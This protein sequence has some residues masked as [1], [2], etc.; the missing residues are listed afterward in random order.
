MS[1]VGDTLQL[2]RYDNCWKCQERH[3]DGDTVSRG[4]NMVCHEDDG[5]TKKTKEPTL[6]RFSFALSPEDKVKVEKYALALGV[7]PSELAREAI[8]ELI[9][10]LEKP[11]EELRIEETELSY[12]MKKMEDRMAAL[13]AKLT[14]AAAQSLYFSTLPYL[15]GGLPKE[16][17]PEGAM[18]TLW[19][20]SRQFAGEWLKKAQPSA[21]DE[22]E[23]AGESEESDTGSEDRD[24][25]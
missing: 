24:K 2:I 23:A 14:R 12:R 22:P 6:V 20:Q 8:K 7:T 19:F 13:L 16:P 17:L 18:K 5:M 10:N 3:L 11:T 1:V 9:F 21:L 4:N 15:Y 25:S